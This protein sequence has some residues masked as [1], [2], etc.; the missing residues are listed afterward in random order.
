[1][2]CQLF[3]QWAK[4]APPPSTSKFL[5]SYG[6]VEIAQNLLPSVTGSI[7]DISHEL[8]GPCVFSSFSLHCLVDR[9]YSLENV[10]WEMSMKT[11]R[12]VRWCQDSFCALPDTKKGGPQHWSMEAFSEPSSQKR[13]KKEIIALYYL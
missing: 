8:N 1:M 7:V 2:L 3:G 10:C 11:W 12:A 4:P 6:A 9:L 5:V 13:I